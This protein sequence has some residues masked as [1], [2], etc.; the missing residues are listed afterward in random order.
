VQRACNAKSCRAAR[1]PLPRVVFYAAFSGA[2]CW[3]AV[4]RYSYAQ[5]AV[6]TLKREASSPPASPETPEEEARAALRSAC[7][8]AES[9]PCASP[10]PKRAV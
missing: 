5:V 1:K 8:R 10:S 2:F 4:K 7:R 3:Y 9:V 6:L